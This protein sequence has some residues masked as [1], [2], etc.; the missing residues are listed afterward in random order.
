MAFLGTYDHSVDAKGR[1]SLPARFR[2]ELPE[3]VIIVPV[4]NPDLGHA[5]FVFSDEAFKAW[6]ADFFVGGPDGDDGYNKNNK[7][8][9]SLMRYLNANSTQ[10]SVDAAGRIK[11]SAEQRARVGIEK[12]V[13]I[14]GGDDHIEIW[15]AS[16]YVDKGEVDDPFAG[17]LV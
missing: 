15:D 12:D 1:V 13:K 17:F 16:T 10:E 9:L 14:I 8:H 2:K 4:N 7:R 5:L 11:L 3:E 6:R